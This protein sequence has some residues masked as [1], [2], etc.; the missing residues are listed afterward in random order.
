MERS[1]GAAMEG[2]KERRHG[3]GT[4]HD[5]LALALHHPHSQRFSGFRASSTVITDQEKRCGAPFLL[6]LVI[7][8]LL[9][10]VHVTTARPAPARAAWHPFNQLIGLVELK[11]YLARFCHMHIDPS[12]DLTDASDEHLEVILKRYTMH[13]KLSLPVRPVASHLVTFTTLDNIMFSR[14]GAGVYVS[15]SAR[16]GGVV[17]WFRLFPDEPR[18]SRLSPMMLTYALSPT[19]IIDYLPSA[20]SASRLQRMSSN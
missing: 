15:H 18:W 4:V 13:A 5:V 1:I 20:A 7:L 11:R 16:Q 17:G 9:P 3:V 14:Y 12:N 19:Y 6:L 10:W 8:R 2:E